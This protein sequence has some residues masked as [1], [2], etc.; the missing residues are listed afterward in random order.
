MNR[1]REGVATKMASIVRC[2][3]LTRAVQYRP[4]IALLATFIL[5]A[6]YTPA[7]VSPCRWPE[8]KTE[9]ENLNF[10][11]G[12]VGAAPKGWLLGPEWFMPPHVP[13]YEAITVPAAQCHG[14][15]QCVTVHSLRSDP[16]LSFLYQDLDVTQ[17][18][19]HT[20]IYRAFVRVDPGA[21]GVARLLVRLHRKDCSTTFRDDM[22]N[23][24]V[25]SRDWAP[26]EIRAPIAMDAYHMEFGM[27][28]IGQGAA[29]IDRIS[30]EFAP[31]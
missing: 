18:R 19:G 6:R 13:I 20:L 16:G 21:K 11:D 31:L 3:L 29:W 12:A 26:Y 30:M 5:S 9:A 22:G 28:L 24:P 10:A 23:H 4:L 15:R 7:Q 2:R 8:M 17:H 25:T 1:D 27:Q 14:G